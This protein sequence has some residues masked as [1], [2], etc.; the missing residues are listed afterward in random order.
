MNGV[1]GQ[2]SLYAPVI[3]VSNHLAGICYSHAAFTGQG[4]L[5]CAVEPTGKDTEKSRMDERELLGI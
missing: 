3:A 5:W 1:G 2:H 4:A